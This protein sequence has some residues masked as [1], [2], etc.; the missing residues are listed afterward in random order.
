MVIFILPKL[1]AN[2]TLYL[3]ETSLKHF[4][5]IKII[6]M[7]STA[8]SPS[9]LYQTVR[10]IALNLISPDSSYFF[11]LHK[12]L[13]I[14]I[15]YWSIPWLLHLILGSAEKLQIRAE[16]AISLCTDENMLNTSET[17]VFDLSEFYWCSKHCLF[18]C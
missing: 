4:M 14:L 7:L 13:L 18:P 8:I 16:F 9:L 11:R 6:I 3:N 5:S 10:I 15:S 17:A 2:L 1:F 12:Y